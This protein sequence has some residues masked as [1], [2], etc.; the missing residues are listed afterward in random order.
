MQTMNHIFKN[1][2]TDG[3]FTLFQK[4]ALNLK[5][6]IEPLEMGSPP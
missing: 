4:K 1:I 2:I 5:S 6:L 3:S